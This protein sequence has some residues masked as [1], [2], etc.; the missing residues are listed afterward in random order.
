MDWKQAILM[1]VK[2][3]APEVLRAILPGA[4]GILQLIEYLKGPKTGP[5]KLELALNTS[6]MYLESMAKAGQLNGPAPVRPEVAQIVQSTV[7][8]MKKTGTL[9][10]AKSGMLD[11][12]ENEKYAIVVIGKL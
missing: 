2:L 8:A 10:E 6:L 1:G 11:L 3:S 12:G 9:V 4:G 5:E 7:D